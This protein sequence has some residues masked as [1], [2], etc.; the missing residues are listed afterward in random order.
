M[1]IDK[2]A[3]R[4]EKGRTMRVACMI[5]RMCGCEQA[6]MEGKLRRQGA[7]SIRCKNVVTVQEMR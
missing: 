7:L 6:R 4:T 5:Q 1:E 3:K 2:R